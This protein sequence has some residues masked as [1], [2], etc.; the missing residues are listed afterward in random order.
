MVRAQPLGACRAPMDFDRLKRQALASLGAPAVDDRP[1]GFSRHAFAKST[2]SDTFDLARLIRSFHVSFPL[3]FLCIG[4]GS[5]PLILEKIR[6]VIE[7][8][9]LFKPQLYLQVPKFVNT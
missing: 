6:P 5:A 8:G 4:I 2:A 3:S 9:R 1:P 7:V